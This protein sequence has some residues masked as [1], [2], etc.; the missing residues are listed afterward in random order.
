MTIL[1]NFQDWVR[2]YSVIKIIQPYKMSGNI[3]I[4]ICLIVNCHSFYNYLK[5]VSYILYNAHVQKN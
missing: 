4:D 3:V 2:S 1:V 5:I